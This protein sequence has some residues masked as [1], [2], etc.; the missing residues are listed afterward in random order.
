MFEVRMT[1]EQCNSI[2]CTQKDKFI[3]NIT[4]L[5]ANSNFM[6]RNNAQKAAD[7]QQCKQIEV[8][9]ILNSTLHKLQ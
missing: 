6:D 4:R 2:H 1:S 5:N 3:A 7:G 8:I 9:H